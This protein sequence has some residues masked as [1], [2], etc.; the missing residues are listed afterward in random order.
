MLIF[1]LPTATYHTDQKVLKAEEAGTLIDFNHL[2]SDAKKE[3]DSLKES[4]ITIQNQEIEKKKEEAYLE[5]LTIFNQHVFALDA[6]LQ[7]LQTHL[8][9]QVLPIAL[10]AAKKIVGEQLKVHPDTIVAMILKQLK[11]CTS[12]RKVKILVSKEDKSIL[13]DK[14]SLLKEKLDQVESFAIEESADISS[15]SCMILT[16]AGNINASLDLQWKA[17]EAAFGRFTKG[18]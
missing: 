15:G 10:N 11:Q 18:A 5:A 14:K 9:K 4:F 12:C 16:E 8:M 7:T 13:D 17:L 6:E 2:L 3:M 1:K